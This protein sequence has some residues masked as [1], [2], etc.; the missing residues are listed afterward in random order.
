MVAGIFFPGSSF[1]AHHL[2]TILESGF[3]AMMPIGDKQLSVG[4]H[5]PDPFLVSRFLQRPE[6]VPHALSISYIQERRSLHSFVQDGADLATPT[7]IERK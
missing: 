5:L 4:Q 1:L 2:A 6:A 7:L 3:V